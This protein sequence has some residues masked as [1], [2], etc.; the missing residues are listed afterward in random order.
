VKVRIHNYTWIGDKVEIGDGS[1]IQAFAFIPNGVT[2][3]KNVFIG[4]GTV[5]TN[6]RTPKANGDWTQENTIVEDDVSIGAH[7]TIAP[8]IR[9]GK[10]AFIKMGCTI[11]NDVPENTTIPAGTVWRY[12]NVDFNDPSRF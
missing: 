11:I 12:K 8:G 1:K 7:C 4:P 5:F 10:G 3:G 2:I 6:D 9:I